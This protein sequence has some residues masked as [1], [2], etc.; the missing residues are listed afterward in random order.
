MGFMGQ[1]LPLISMFVEW[2]GRAGLGEL[3]EFAE[4]FDDRS[5]AA[6]AVEAG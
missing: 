6:F 5:G 1:Q 3:F 2:S 4:F